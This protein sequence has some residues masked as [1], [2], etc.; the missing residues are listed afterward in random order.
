MKNKKVVFIEGHIIANRLFGD[1]SPPFCI[2]RV[3]FSNG[4]YA[5]VRAASG[6]C[7]KPGDVIQRNDCE[8]FFNDEKTRLLSFEYLGENESQRQ[9]LEY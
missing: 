7:F 6:I 5:I 2:H 1:A 4:K 8:W 9:L 3:M